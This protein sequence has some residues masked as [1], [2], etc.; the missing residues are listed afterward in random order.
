MIFPSDVNNY[1]QNQRK[2][3]G[4]NK[5]QLIITLFVIGN[6]AGFF[7]LHYVFV[8]LLG[9]SGSIATAV[10]VVILI[11]IGILVFRFAVFDENAKRHESEGYESDSFAKYMNVR[12]D[13][14]ITLEVGGNTVH[15]FEYSNG[16][17]VC[18]LELKF[19]SNDNVKAVATRGLYQSIVHSVLSYGFICR[20][21]DMTE[22]FKNSAEYSNHIARLNKI[23][24]TQ[25][26][27]CNFAITNAIMSMC[28]EKSNTDVIYVMLQSRGRNQKEDLDGLLRELN[29]I[30]EA[31]ISAF[32]SI[33]YLDI[34]GLLEFFRQ[35]YKIEAIDL[36]MMKTVELS[37]EI[38]DDFANVV[39]IYSLTGNSGKI[40]KSQ[41]NQTIAEISV[42]E[43]HI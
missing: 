24:D 13:N 4:E 32:R 21:I 41:K 40:Y 15:A 11:V 31:Q 29:R 26:R 12:K 17:I 30:F 20:V 5:I 42:R 16:N 3:A 37:K 38:D 39:S 19:G 36:S 18:V 35:F 23:A 7:I 28:N 22:D 27:M 43:R 6:L 34:N 25:L 33:R 10:Q 9:F 8:N 1:I 14:D 2:I